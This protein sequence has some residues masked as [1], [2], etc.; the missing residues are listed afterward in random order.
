ML[1]GRTRDQGC[2]TL[3]AKLG[4][5]GCLDVHKMAQANI[6]DVKRLIKGGGFHRKRAM[7][8]INA[9]QH[10]VKKHDGCSPDDRDKLMEIGG[11]G[12]KIAIAFLRLEGLT[13]QGL[14]CM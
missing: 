7:H 8:L 11:V 13:D 10:T 5:H 9:A 4:S 14:M 6:V 3:A 1:S 2:I 12:L